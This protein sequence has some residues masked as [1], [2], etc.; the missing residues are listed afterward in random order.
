MVPFVRPRYAQLWAGKRK[1]RSLIPSISRPSWQSMLVV[2]LAPAHSQFIFLHGTQNTSNFND[3]MQGGSKC[4]DYHNTWGPPA[5][6]QTCLQ[7]ASKLVAGIQHDRF[8]SLNGTVERRTYQKP[9]VEPNT[10]VLG[11]GKGKGKGN[12]KG[13]GRKAKVP[14]QILGSKSPMQFHAC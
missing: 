10:T 1:K 7:A 9:Q 8:L 12:Q 3:F 5:L 14:K 13:G 6:S 11:A 2:R 4:R